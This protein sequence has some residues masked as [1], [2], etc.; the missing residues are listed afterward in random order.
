[1]AVPAPHL[2]IKPAV[3]IN[4]TDA[5]CHFSQVT[6][7]PNQEF[8]DIE[9]Y[10]NPGGEAPGKVSWRAN[11]RVRMSYGTDSAWTFFSAL[12]GQSALFE[13]RP[14][15]GTVANTNPEASFS[16]YIP[17]LPFIPDHEIGQ[18]ATFDLECRVIGAPVVAT[19]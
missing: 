12:A 15:S 17:A 3:T 2:F 19:T 1:M 16:A 5:I 4:S 6:L 13:I 7:V 9:T 8:V 18:S 10:C 11:L 14:D